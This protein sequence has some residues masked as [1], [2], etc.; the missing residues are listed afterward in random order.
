MNHNNS[1]KT[2]PAQ[3]KVKGNHRALNYYAKAVKRFFHHKL[4]VLGLIVLCVVI[5]LGLFAPVFAPYDPTEVGVK[6]VRAKPSSEHCLGTDELGRDIL[7]RIIY[8]ARITLLVVVI[9]I[10]FALLV[11]TVLGL[12]AG[13]KGGIVDAVIMRIMDAILSFPMLILALA[14]IAILGPGLYNAMI[15]ISIVYT[16]YFARLVRGQVLSIKESE[17]VTASRSIGCSESYII[18][19]EI[20]PN[21]LDSIIVFSS[22]RASHAIIIESSLSFLGL[23]AQPP[24]PSWGWMIAVGIK[25][26]NVGW[27]MSFFPGMVIFITV[28]SINLMGDALQDA[29]NPQLQ[30]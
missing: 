2:S 30:M 24:I 21:C 6:N 3:L 27:W 7:S 16:P 14:I 15:A 10:S 9:S 5:L 26:W 19:R 8:G 29:F 11:G 25:Y 4:G 23:G 13:Y 17:Y 1:I 20:L 28:L 12:V 22:L 18:F